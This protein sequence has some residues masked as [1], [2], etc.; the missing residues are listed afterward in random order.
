MVSLAVT[1]SEKLKIAGA[2]TG[3]GDQ[4]VVGLL[5]SYGGL[6][7]PPPPSPPIEGVQPPPWRLQELTVAIIKATTSQFHVMPKE[8]HVRSEWRVG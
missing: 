7:Q 8:K 3:G 5:C 6:S 1:F 2:K 4:K